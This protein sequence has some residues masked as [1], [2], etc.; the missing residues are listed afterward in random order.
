MAISGRLGKLPRHA[1]HISIHA[2]LIG[3]TFVSGDM[4]YFQ[5]CK[6][7]SAAKLYFCAFVEEFL[8]TE[9]TNRK[10]SSEIG[11]DKV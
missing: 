9:I 11:I 1:K 6:L 5:T 4:Q 7:V 8:P 10:C 2:F 3:S